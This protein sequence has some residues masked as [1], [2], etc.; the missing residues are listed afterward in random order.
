MRKTTALIL[1]WL[2]MTPAAFAF[3]SDGSVVTRTLDRTLSLTNQPIVMMVTFTNAATNALR[4]FCY[5][6]QVPSSATISPMAVTLNG[7]AITNY[8]FESGQ[9]GDVY[10]GCTPHRWVLESPTNFAEANPIPPQGHV[11]IAYAIT[12]TNPGTFVF[13][14]CSWA[15]Y[16]PDATNES[17]GYGEIAD[18]LPASFIKAVLT[19]AADDQT[20]VYAT[21]N[22][23]LTVN[24]SGFVAGDDTNVLSGTPVLSTTATTVSPPGT[25][26]ISI[27]QGSLNANGYSLNFVHGELTVAWPPSR[28]KSVQ[29]TDGVITIRWLSVAGQRYRVQYK[30]SLGEE[31]WNDLPPDVTATG[32]TASKTDIVGSLPQRFYRI[33]LVPASSL[34]SPLIQTMQVANGVVTIEWSSVAGQ[35]YRV[36]YK[37]ALTD[38]N[39]TD[40]PPEVTATG[41]TA[42]KVDVVGTRPQRFYR[43]L[44]LPTLPM[45]PLIHPLSLSNGVVTITWSS[46]AGQTYRVQY[47]NSLSD[48]IWADLPIEVTATGPMASTTD[49]VGDQPQRFYRVWFAP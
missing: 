38:A 10:P 7:L 48:E 32:P 46:A 16:S 3:S 4:G 13:Q 37:N 2:G 9:D 45:S 14:E 15:A 25:Y 27:S 23:P 22:P 20:R 36:Q 28:I 30:N 40:L 47:K 44:L 19:V 11:Q 18:A 42:S 49:T 43:V 31:Q 8:T 1:C 12:A 5:T 29:M 21:N 24:Y 26:P 17:F 39:W 33:M 34:P 35:V 41:Q 6:D